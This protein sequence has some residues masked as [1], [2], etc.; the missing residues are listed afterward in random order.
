[1][2]SRYSSDHSRRDAADLA[3]NLGI[4]FRE[5]SIEPMFAAYLDQLAPAFT[6]REP[7]VTEENLQ[8]RVR[9]GL[10]MAL[11]NKFGKLL[12]STGNKSEIAT[13]YCT[14]YGD[15]NGGLAVISDVPKTLVYKIAR[16]INADG[17]VIPES[18]LTK[19]PS[20]ELRPG[21]VDQ[22]SL[23]PYDVLDAI[24]AAHIEDGLDSSALLQKG[25]KGGHVVVGGLNLGG[26]IDPV[27]NAVNVVELAVEKGASNIVIPISARRQLNDLPD[28][29]AIKINIQYYT[30]VREVLLKVLET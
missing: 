3:R 30:D 24:L 9:G 18:T 12:L 28:D 14:L 22:D 23:P 5:I 2:P 29:L 8:A 10:L 26:S 16:E 19:P 25:I 27:H 17:P 7:D 11:S 13:G 15:T 1:M 21:Q 20:A 6:G 4:E